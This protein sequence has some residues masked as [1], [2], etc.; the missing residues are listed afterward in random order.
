MTENEI[1]Q[2]IFS[3]PK[4]YAPIK[5]DRGGFMNAQDANQLK[6]RFNKGTIS[7]EIIEKIFNHHGYF[8]ADKSWVKK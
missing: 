1:A 8:I 6:R 2:I 3:T 4:W 5:K 7:H